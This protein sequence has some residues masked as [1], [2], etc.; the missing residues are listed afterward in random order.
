M[1]RFLFHVHTLQSRTGDGS[2]LH[3]MPHCS[4]L[5]PFLPPIPQDIGRVEQAVNDCPPVWPTPEPRDTQKG[6]EWGASCLTV[7]A[8]GDRRVTA[9]EWRQSAK[10]SAY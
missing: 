5:P 3:S 1:K 6:S 2:V 4:V 9:G 7:S 10:E 8:A